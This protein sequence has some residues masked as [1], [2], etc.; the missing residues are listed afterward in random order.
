[1]GNGRLARL[2]LNL[3]LQQHGYPLVVVP[4]PSGP[5]TTPPVPPRPAASPS[6]FWTARELVSAALR[7]QLRAARGETAADTNPLHEKLALLKQLVLGSED[8]VKTLWNEAVQA[9]AYEALVQPWLLSLLQQT[10]EFDELFMS[11]GY[12]GSVDAALP[13]PLVLEEVGDW[14]TFEAHFQSALTITVA[15][16][17][18]VHFTTRWLHF[19]QRNN[20]FDTGLRVDFHFHSDHFTVEQAIVGNHG[21]GGLE[22]LWQAEVYRAGYPLAPDAPA[23]HEINYL[24]ATRLY[25]LIAAQA[26]PAV[27]LA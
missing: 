8:A 22:V 13:R 17:Q 18:A 20:G 2:L 5:A 4:A 10:Q 11:R 3:V 6:R 19:R 12:G 14:E 27:L 21:G 9:T 24:L 23:V 15:E 1:M 16:V 25:D 7:R 26:A